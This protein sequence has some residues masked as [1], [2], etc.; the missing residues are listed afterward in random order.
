[1]SASGND[2]MILYKAILYK[3]S[4]PAIDKHCCLEFTIG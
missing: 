3:N 4:Q 2:V 1:M